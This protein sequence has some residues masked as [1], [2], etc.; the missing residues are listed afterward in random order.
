M[1][2]MAITVRCGVS[3]VTIGP[4]GDAGRAARMIGDNPRRR[5]S[6]EKRR[7]ISISILLARYCGDAALVRR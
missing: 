5:T 3:A 7:V 4:D 6:T 1:L 2:A